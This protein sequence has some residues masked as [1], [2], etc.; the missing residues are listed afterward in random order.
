VCV[1]ILCVCVFVCVIHSTT[2]TGWQSQT[3]QGQEWQLAEGQ[4][5]QATLLRQAVINTQPP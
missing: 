3:K 1:H 2:G 5:R 4:G